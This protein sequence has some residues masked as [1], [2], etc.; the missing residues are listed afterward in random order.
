MPVV[1]S[2]CSN[3]FDPGQPCPRCGAPSP[4]VVTANASTPG[5]GPRWQQTV[6]GRLL[7]GLVLAQGL[8]YGLRHLLTGVLLAVQ[9]TEGDI[10]DDSRNVFLLFSIQLFAAF[11]GGVFAGSG[12]RYGYLLGVFV[13]LWNGVLAALLRQNAGGEFLP[14]GFFTHPLSQS[15]TALLGGVI[16]SMVWRPIIHTEPVRLAP[17]SKKAG[18][19]SAPLLA[20]PIAWVRVLIGC[21]AVVSASLYASKLLDKILDLTGTKLSTG[22]DL[23][24]TIIIW[25]IRGFLILLGASSAGA[26]TKNGCAS[27]LNA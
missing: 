9:E 26:T 22:D 4:V 8:F 20:G 19:Q 16:G 3:H 11:V 23:Q 24:D 7:I 27:R 5:H 1:C 17:T 12:Q 10:W 21:I 2:R 14:L 13:G 15:G 18:K 6:V 25:Q